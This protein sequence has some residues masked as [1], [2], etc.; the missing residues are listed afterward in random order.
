MYI[1]IDSKKLE[2][3][4]DL[5]DKEL[6]IAYK[7]ENELKLLQKSEYGLHFEKIILNQLA[8]IRNEIDYIQ[9]RKHLLNTVKELI[10]STNREVEE[11]ISN[12]KGILKQ[13]R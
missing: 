12:A 3:H 1:S 4:F 10:Y 13:I 7:I 11:K 5:I 2:D 9:H 6:M 8:F